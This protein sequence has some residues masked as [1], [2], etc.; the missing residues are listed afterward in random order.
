MASAVGALGAEDRNVARH[1]G[2]LPHEEVARP[3]WVARGGGMGA[4]GGE[5]AAELAPEAVAGR[6]VAWSL[7]L[8]VL[9]CLETGGALRGDAGAE[10]RHC[11]GQHLP[12]LASPPHL[13]K[14]LALPLLEDDALACSANNE[15]ILQL[16]KS[17]RAT[18]F[19]HLGVL[20]RARPF[21]RP[22][23]GRRARRHS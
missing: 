10:L 12:A 11:Q 1:V 4:R 18:A 20:Q 17:A 22:R 19:G 5:M 7:P 13:V 9:Y 23:Q 15:M 14:S 2:R 3:G 6:R 8:G 21:H 16:G